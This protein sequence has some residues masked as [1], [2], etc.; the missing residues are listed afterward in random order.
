MSLD[1]P[2]IKGLKD[3]EVQD[4]RQLAIFVCDER[5]DTLKLCKLEIEDMAHE[6]L[7]HLLQEIKLY[8]L[9]QSGLYRWL[10]RKRLTDHL[11]VKGLYTRQG[12]RSEQSAHLSTSDIEDFTHLP[13]NDTSF[14]KLFDCLTVEALDP[15]GELSKPRKHMQPKGQAHRVRL[16]KKHYLEGKTS[17]EVSAEVGRKP[18][19]VEVVLCKTRRLLRK[20][21]SERLAEHCSQLHTRGLV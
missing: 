7:I 17:K 21:R 19:D 5:R 10:L 12:N 9:K 4:L 3:S 2:L 1:A 18:C 15:I 20:Y 13:S 16:V 11:R 14:H 8:D 6:I